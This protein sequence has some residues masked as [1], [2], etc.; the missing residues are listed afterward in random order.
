MAAPDYTEVDS[1]KPRL[2]TVLFLFFSERS[3]SATTGYPIMWFVH[4]F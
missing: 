1:Q 3:R 2:D 4:E